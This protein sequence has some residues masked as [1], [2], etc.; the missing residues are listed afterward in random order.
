MAVKP[1]CAR[2]FVRCDAGVHNLWMVLDVDYQAVVQAIKDKTGENQAELAAR[3]GVSQPTVSRW[4]GG[5]PPELHHA[6]VIDRVARDLRLGKRKSGANMTTVP[7]VGYVGARGTISFDEGQGP[8]GDAD[9]PPKDGNSSLV[10]VTV[11]GDSMSGTLEDGWTVYYDNRKD[12]PDESLHAKLCIVG[13][14]D[15]RVLIKK[16]YPGRKRDHYDLHSVNA[17]ALLDQHVTWAAR[18]T[19]IATA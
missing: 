3:F 14:V 17:P 11:R 13:L 12:P 4:L 2:V 15:G 1:L 10:A 8:F 5:T 9:M 16:L 18:I 19:W 7:I 6:T